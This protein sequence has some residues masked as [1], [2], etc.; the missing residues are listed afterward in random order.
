MSTVMP[1]RVTC[2]VCGKETEFSV[3]GSTNSFGAPDLDLR[4]A[5]MRRLTMEYWVQECPECGFV[6]THI[7]QPLGCDRSVLESE[8]YRTCDGITF[9]HDLA[10]RF[11]RQYVIARTRNKPDLCFYAA[12]HAAWVCD[13]CGDKENAVTCRK[14][15]AD[16]AY[17][18]LL[19]SEEERPEDLILQRADLLRRAG[20]FDAAIK[21]L[22]GFTSQ[23]E[24]HR[25]VAAFQIEKCRAGDTERYTVLQATNPLFQ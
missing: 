5:P 18:L 2:S 24:A 8:A 11:Y 13:D 20:E 7:D 17:T 15:A 12:L 9:R 21:V 10:A 14:I 16:M 6:A 4:P 1:L 19:S 3:L 25:T 22:D 23:H